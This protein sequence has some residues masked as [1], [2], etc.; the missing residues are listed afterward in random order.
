LLRV[1]AALAEDQSLVQCPALTPTAP[2]DPAP[3]LRGNLQAC[4]P[5]RHSQINSKNKY[6]KEL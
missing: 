4:A 5:N 1:L 2:E 3:V 6:E